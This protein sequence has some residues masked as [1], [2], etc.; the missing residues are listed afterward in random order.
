ML[1][2]TSIL[3]QPSEILLRLFTS[4]PPIRSSDAMYI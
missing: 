1:M 2:K 3:I 4:H